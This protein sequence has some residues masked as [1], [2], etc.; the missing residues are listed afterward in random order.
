MTSNQP[1]GL[2]KEPA[3]GAQGDSP[4]DIAYLGTRLLAFSGLPP[5]ASDAATFQI[6]ALCPLG[7]A[8]CGDAQTVREYLSFRVW[9]LQEIR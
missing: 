5:R 8:L 4:L 1:T 2:E 6:Q 3:S 9:E 7:I